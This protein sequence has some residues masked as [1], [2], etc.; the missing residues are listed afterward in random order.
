MYLA[1]FIGGAFGSSLREIFAQEIPSLPF[2]S[3]TFGI[4]IAAC[5]ILGALYAIRHHLH[6]HILHMGAVGFCGGLST[7]SA[8]MAEI[9]RLAQNNLTLAF[10]APVLEIIFGL[11]AAMLGAALAQRFW[12]GEAEQ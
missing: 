4:N 9:Y 7:F 11:G 10:A 2:V 12:P 8:F 5:L 1:V 6:A 3:A